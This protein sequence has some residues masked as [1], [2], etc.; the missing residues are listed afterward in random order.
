[1]QN[2]GISSYMPSNDVLLIYGNVNEEYYWSQDPVS[3]PRNHCFSEILGANEQSHE[4][5]S[6]DNLNNN[7]RSKVTSE[8]IPT[9]K[10]TD[11]QVVPL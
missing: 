2:E 9:S 11:I 1:M 5:V 7:L 10:S 4:Y 6:N 3:Y 8:T